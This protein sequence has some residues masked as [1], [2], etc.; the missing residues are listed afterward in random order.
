MPIEVPRALK[1]EHD[2]LHAELKHAT[3]AGGRTGAAASAVVQLMH[4]HFAS[5]EEFAL[6]PLGLLPELSRGKIGT[7]I[8]AVLKLTDRLERELP[9]MVAEHKEI[10]TALQRL[11]EATNAEGKPDIAAFA[12]KLMAHA[13]AEEEVSYPAAVLIGRYLKSVFGSKADAGCSE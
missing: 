7:E 9:R 3:S 12:H 5:E 1:T 2:E 8:A 13:R 10:V 4:P 11:V 6:P